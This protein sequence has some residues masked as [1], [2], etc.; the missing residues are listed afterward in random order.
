M[1]TRTYDDVLRKSIKPFLGIGRKLSREELDEVCAAQEK[2][3]E[4]LHLLDIDRIDLLGATPADLVK[5]IMGHLATIK[6]CGCYSCK[7]SS[8]RDL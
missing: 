5:G 4:K 6:G 8:R 7:A 1:T 2:F 3:G